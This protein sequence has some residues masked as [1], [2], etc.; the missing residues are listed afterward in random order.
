MRLGDLLRG[1]FVD[2]ENDEWSARGPAVGLGADPGAPQY[3][4]RRLV[5]RVRRRML[6]RLRKEIEPVAP[7]DLMRF[8]FRW[9]RVDE[10]AHGPEGLRKVLETLDGAS[11]PAASWEE[12]VLPARVEDY[13]SAWLD[14]LCLSGQ[15]EWTRIEPSSSPGIL[16]NTSMAIVERAHAHLFARPVVD[17]GALSANA[18]A[19]LEVLRTRGASF[20]ADLARAG[21]LLP[22]HAEAALA[23]LVAAGVATSDGYAGLRALLLSGKDKERLRRRRARTGGRLGVG[24]GLDAAGRWTLAAA[25]HVDALDDETRCEAVAR[26]LLRRTGVV[27]RKLV[28]REPGLPPWRDVLWALRRLEARGEIRGGR[29]VTGFS[30]E[31]FALP[32]AVGLLRAVRREPLGR[33]RVVLCA[34]DPLNLTGVILPG[35]RIAAVPAHRVLFEDGIALAALDG[36]GVRVLVEGAVDAGEIDGLLRRRGRPTF[37]HLVRAP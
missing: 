35:A 14:Q 37:A 15:V 16:R 18:K 6:E 23:E 22:E 21:R 33:K 25:A 26:V 20:F 7:R 3:W 31:Q 30:G 9:Q 19:V 2:I 24:V 10:K 29:F 28:E 5:A 36:G 11:A 13:E 32:E 8:L 1:H 12:D 17:E 27:F 4:S 34:A